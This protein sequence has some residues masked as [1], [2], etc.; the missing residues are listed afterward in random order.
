MVFSIINYI[1]CLGCVDDMTIE[2]LY[3]ITK[4]LVS[5]NKGKGLVVIQLQDQ[6]AYKTLDKTSF[7]GLISNPN[8][9][10]ESGIDVVFVNDKLEPFG[11]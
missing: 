3:E 1:S 10:L 9:V 2:E 5:S 6:F 11:V 7:R 8:L 4:E